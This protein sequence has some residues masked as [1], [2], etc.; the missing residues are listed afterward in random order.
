MEGGLPSL[1]PA[2]GEGGEEGVHLGQVVVQEHG[3]VLR[4]AHGGGGAAPTRPILAWSL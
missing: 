2:V 4:G 3:G 1:P